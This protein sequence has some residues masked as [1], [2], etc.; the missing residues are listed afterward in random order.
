MK[1][2]RK[3]PQQLISIGI[4]FILIVILFIVARKIFIP[5]SF[6]VLG[7]YRAQAIEEN[8]AREII[9]AGAAACYDCHDAIYELKA[10]SYHKDV[11][12]ETCHGPAAKHAED[13]AQYA[14][15]V[16]RGRDTCP[17]CH[18]Y[19]PSR[20]TG[21]PQIIAA[22][23]NPGKAC[24][25]CH[26]PHN[27]TPPTPDQCSACHRGIVSEKSVSHH[28]GLECTVCHTVPE[29]H[30][31][32]P[33]FVKVGKPQKK[34]LCGKCHARG[35]EGPKEIPKVDL[36]THGGRYLCWECHYPHSPNVER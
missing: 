15:I 32:T 23:H 29:E 11:A 25:S 26:N 7:H 35:T 22:K 10:T 13:P 4:V 27:P 5:P 17:I 9:Y 31:V 8:K 12:C 3:I 14:P 16:P 30:F 18:D 36:A 21:F 1:Y 2:F 6:G 24:M 28:A 33:R 34:E 19:N 20:P